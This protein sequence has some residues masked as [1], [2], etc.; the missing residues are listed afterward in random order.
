MSHIGK[1]LGWSLGMCIA[2]RN[3]AIVFPWFRYAWSMPRIISGI[4]HCL[5]EAEVISAPSLTVPMYSTSGELVPC[6]LSRT[7]STIVLRVGCTIC[8]WP[9]LC[10]LPIILQT[11]IHNSARHPDNAFIALAPQHQWKQ[12]PICFHRVLLSSGITKAVTDLWPLTTFLMAYPVIVS[13]ICQSSVTHAKN[14]YHLL[15][16]IQFKLQDSAAYLTPMC[17]PSPTMDCSSTH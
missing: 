13:L 3:Q 17:S 5:W 10:T 4:R 2:C 14:I 9:R 6:C 7:S 15:S 12:S 1:G 11:G 8:L 16:H